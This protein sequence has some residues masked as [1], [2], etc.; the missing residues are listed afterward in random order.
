MRFFRITTRELMLGVAIVAVGIVVTAVVI[1][2]RRS[3]ALMAAGPEG[4]AERAAGPGPSVEEDVSGGEGGTGAG[5]N[6]KT[7][8]SKTI[9]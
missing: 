1:A 3:S 4:A 5:E 7:A 6:G 9:T 2:K 8:A